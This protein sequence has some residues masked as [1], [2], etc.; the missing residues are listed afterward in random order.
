MI[1]LTITTHSGS[2]FHAEVAEY[3]PVQIN[4]DLN[5]NT[6]NTV[7]FGDVIISR[8]DVKSVVKVTE[9]AVE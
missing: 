4:D 2:E 7:V 3:N 5:N 1:K 8:V 6:I 9:E